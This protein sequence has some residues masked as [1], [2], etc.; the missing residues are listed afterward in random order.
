MLRRLTSI[1][2]AL[3]LA[4]VAFSACE[5]GTRDGPR[6]EDFT[7]EPLE[8]T[9]PNPTDFRVYSN[10][11]NDIV[12]K[13]GSEFRGF[14]YAPNAFVQVMNS[15]DYY[16]VVWAEEVELKN[17]GDFYIDVALLDMFWSSGVYIAS[18]REVR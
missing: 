7:Y 8:F 5:S 6:P 11:S 2:L 12:F 10:S 18:W 16:G 14:V 4:V 17:G 1:S 13:H 3:V 15:A 9:A